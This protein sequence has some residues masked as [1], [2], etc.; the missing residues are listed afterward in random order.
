MH[1]FK[2]IRADGS[3]F[4]ALGAYFD[5]RQEANQA[6]IQWKDTHQKF[7]GVAYSVKPTSCFE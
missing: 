3:H 7:S 2:I 5:T 6:I 1:K 4:T